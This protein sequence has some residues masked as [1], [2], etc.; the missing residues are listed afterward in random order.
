LNSNSNII[1][2]PGKH[3]LAHVTSR[4]KEETISSSMK[5]RLSGSKN[6]KFNTSFENPAP[7][8]QNNSGK[9]NALKIRKVKPSHNESGSVRKKTLF[10][11]EGINS[12]SFLLAH[13]MN[14]K[15]KK[16]L[17]KHSI[18]AAIHYHIQRMAGQIQIEG[19]F[20]MKQLYR[21]IKLSANA[22]QR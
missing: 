5:K 3:N 7:N 19:Q 8:F 16:H 10:L 11:I 21:S 15:M 14:L 2:T 18:I 1:T 17:I 9:K 13:S 6:V 4:F 20:L 12:K 22:C